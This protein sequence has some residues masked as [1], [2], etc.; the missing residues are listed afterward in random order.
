[1]MDLPH[2]AQQSSQSVSVHVNFCG[3]LNK[4]GMAVDLPKSG[5]LTAALVTFGTCFCGQK[6]PIELRIHGPEL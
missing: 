1:M 5:A 6:Q 4:T 2:A 3:E